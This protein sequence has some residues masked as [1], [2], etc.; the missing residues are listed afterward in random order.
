MYLYSCKINFSFMNRDC[1]QFYS[2]TWKI[3]IMYNVR[4]LFNYTNI[5]YPASKV[6]AIKNICIVKTV[7]NVQLRYS[8]K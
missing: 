5:C 8:V 7:L 2:N 1:F 6:N 4:K 3:K